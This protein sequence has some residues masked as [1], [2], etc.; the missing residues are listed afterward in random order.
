MCNKEGF[1]KKRRV[2]AQLVDAITCYSN[3]DEA[4]EEDSAQDEE[5]DQGEKRKKLDGCKKRKRE[6]MLYTNCKARMVVKMI[7]S[8]WQVI[9]FLA[10]HNHD[11]VVKPSLKKFLRSQRGIPKPEKDFIIL[12]HGCNLSTGRIMQLMREFYGSAQLVPYEGKQVLKFRST[13]H[14]TKKFK[15]MQETLDYFRALKEDPDFFYKIKLDDNNRVEN[16]FWGD[17]F[18]RQAYKAAAIAS[19]LMQPI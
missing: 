6:K 5:D 10:E 3:N 7:G 9:Y 14:K 13:I 18:A 4:E 8:R 15:D 17:S 11:L 19:H 1:G 2:A 12:L 16:L